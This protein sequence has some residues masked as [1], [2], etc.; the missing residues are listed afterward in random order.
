[1]PATGSVS[2]VTAR[3]LLS[4]LGLRL[5]AAFLT[6]AVAAVAVLAALTLAS[7]RSEVSD[8]VRDV[9]R[10]D[11]RAAAS[12]AARAYGAA[13]GWD[14]A[15]F[16]GAAA[17]A[18]RGQADL[19]I[20]TADG[21]VLTAEVH[22]VHQMMAIM[23]GVAMVQVPRG[24]PVSAPIV[25]D[26]HTVGTVEL[27]FPISHL[28]TPERQIR[29]ALSRNAILGALF[30]I[31][32]AIAMA[33]FVAR[34]V[35]RPI[36]ALTVA[37]ADLEAG[38]RDVRVD[39]AQAPGELG[40]LAATFDRMA[41]AVA[42]QD[43]LRRQLVADVA[44]EVRTPLTILRGTTEALADGVVQPDEAT[45]ASLHE[46]V[47]R[48]TR[49]VGDLETLASADAAGLHLE[50]R[51]VDLGGAAAAVVD[52][53]QP[54]AE[55]A[56]LTMTAEIAPAPVV[57]DESRL[58]Q[59]VTTLLANALAYTP[60]GGAISVRSGVEGD[61]AVVE[62]SDTGPGI[63][64][65]DLPHLFERFYRGRASVGTTGSGIGL[66]VAS[67]LAADHEGSI[68]AANRDGGGAVFTVRLPLR[69]DGKAVTA[70]EADESS[71]TTG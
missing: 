30:A 58:R 24:D 1:M 41:A 14:G 57:A 39:L 16:T 25:T 64:E 28:P 34:A 43:E 60:A 50:L 7:A 31:A 46:E 67:E 56:D 48:L 65:E 19:K 22:E 40:T 44:H 23:H 47:L 10:N 29:D 42:R 51:P 35:S 8:L 4:P 69:R 21:R 61:R 37:A 62:V 53:A 32:A 13:G 12:A 66:A 59:I 3:R 63:D 49:V 38:R 11:T 18:A 68:T 27:R 36:T 52:L 26:G 70:V 33:V 45:I 6:V 17:V 55:A 20:V 54:A 2:L 15:D 5:A 9:H 71:D